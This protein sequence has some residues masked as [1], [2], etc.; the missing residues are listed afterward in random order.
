MKEKPADTAL[1]SA[2]ALMRGLIV[3]VAAKADVHPSFVTRVIDGE[4]SS[5]AV[6]AALHQELKVVRDRLIETVGSKG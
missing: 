5:P 6:L 4:R 2:V 3:R 1:R